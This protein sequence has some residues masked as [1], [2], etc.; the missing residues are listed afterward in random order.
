MSHSQF[1]SKGFI[2]RRAWLSLWDERMTTGRIN[3]VAVLTRHGKANQ[4]NQQIARRF[5]SPH[6]TYARSQNRPPSRLGNSKIRSETSFWRFHPLWDPLDDASADTSPQMVQQLQASHPGNPLFAA[7]SNMYKISPTR[8]HKP[9]RPRTNFSLRTEPTQWSTAVHAPH[10]QKH[11]R[12]L[13]LPPRD[14]TKLRRTNVLKFLTAPHSVTA[15]QTS[16]L[17]QSPPAKQEKD[18][19]RQA[20]IIRLPLFSSLMEEK[21]PNRLFVGFH[22]TSNNR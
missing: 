15:Y 9:A 22:I 14:G 19:D 1:Q 12:T 10:P 2:L 18:A 17:L 20:Q 3:Q 8:R 13:P 6:H 4:T 11:S 16:P 21:T 7:R 5:S